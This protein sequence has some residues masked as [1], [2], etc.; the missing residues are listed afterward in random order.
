MAVF[1]RFETVREI[2]QTGLGSV[3]TAREAGTSGG[4]M[5][6]SA[7]LRSTLAPGERYIIKL[8]QPLGA[9][10]G[11]PQFDAEI[12]GFLR[13]VQ[14]QRRMAERAKRWA[15]V[16]ASGRFDEGAYAV[17]DAHSRSL[18]QFVLRKVDLWR[19]GNVRD[20]GSTLRAII[21]G[22][23]EAL[24]E[25]SG[26]ENG[27][28]HGSLRPSNVLLAG[29]GP[30]ATARPILTDPLAD[31]PPRHAE[32]ARRD[33]RDLGALIFQLVTHRP[34]RE[35]GAWPIEDG[36]EWR[37]YG[38]RGGP[39]WLDLCNRLLDPRAGASLPAL[40]QIHAELDAWPIERADRRIPIAI[41]AVVLL[42]LGGAGIWYATRPPPRP[43]LVL[44]GGQLDQLKDDINWIDALA[45]IAAD[46]TVAAA[47]RSDPALAAIVEPVRAYTAGDSLSRAIK[48]LRYER[49][50][51]DLEP[52]D[53]TVKLGVS[54]LWR[55][56]EPVT[57]AIAAWPV[58][59]SL[60]SAIQT[61]EQ[62][63]WTGVSRA[64][65]EARA[66][67]EAIL[68]SRPSQTADDSARAGEARPA[69]AIRS[70]LESARAADDIESLWKP[71]TAR[72]AE[73][74][75]TEDAVLKLYGPAIEG[76][77]RAA[78]SGD[79]TAESLQRELMELTRLGAEI[80]AAKEAHYAK[81]DLEFFAE[82]SRV[83][84]DLAKLAGAVSPEQAVALL[85]AWPGEIAQPQFIREP[86]GDVWA[87]RE[88]EDEVAAAAADMQRLEAKR[89]PGDEARLDPM[90]RHLKESQ[91]ALAGLLKKLEAPK[92]REYDAIRGDARTLLTGLDA[93]KVE[94][95]DLKEL[96][97]QEFEAY[98]PKFRART[99]ESGSAA[100]DSAFI[101][102]R[103]AIDK[104]H[105]DTKDIGELRDR[106]DR[107]A[108][109]LARL[110]ELPRVEGLSGPSAQIAMA[111][112]E[113]ALTEAIAQL[114][115]DAEG[116]PTAEAAASEVFNSFWAQRTGEYEAWLAEARAALIE[117]D[118]IANLLA[119][120]YGPAHDDGDG[121]LS[122][123]WARLA[124]QPAFGQL[125][126]QQESLRA[127]GTRLD[128]IAQINASTDRA[129]LMQTLE[130]A[131]TPLAEGMAA[132]SRLR[133][134]G[135]GPW[136]ASAEDLRRAATLLTGRLKP[137]AATA[138]SESRRA[139]LSGW[140]DDQAIKTWTAGFEAL[141][142]E[143][144]EIEAGA[145]LA[146]EF[147]VN[148]ADFAKL[149]PAAR[150]NL[151]LAGLRNEF[152]AAGTP[153]DDEA[154]RARLRRFDADVAGLGAGDAAMAGL[155]G[156]LREL[157]NAPPKKEVDLATVGPGS[158]G[159]T[160]TDA[161]AD[162]SWVVYAGPAASMPPLRFWRVSDGQAPG[163][164]PAAY[165]CEVETSLAMFAGI[166]EAAKG[167][168]DV[169]KLLTRLDA[170]PDPRKG[171]SAWSLTRR[172]ARGPS[173]PPI[174]LRTADTR[175]VG[176]GWLNVVA[177]MDRG[178]AYYPTGLQVSP[179]TVDCP[180]NYLPATAAI[181]TARLA[182]CRLPTPAEWT[183]A[184]AMNQPGTPN[185]RDKS[186][187]DQHA[188][189]VAQREGGKVN[190]PWPDEDIF[191]PEERKSEISARRRRTAQPVTDQDADRSLWFLP[192]S[193]TG[194]G[195]PFKHLRGN[196]AEV[197]FENSERLDG[198][199]PAA[200]L[201]NTD[202][203]G[204]K[205]AGGSA[206]SPVEVDTGQVYNAPSANAWYSDVG[207]R[208][209]FS[210]GE[211]K[212]KPLIVQAGQV[213]ATAKYIAGR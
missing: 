75:T 158:V 99:L 182:G 194:H 113:N 29:E 88:V 17:F 59:G 198:L 154:V 8:F 87:G 100:L 19:T 45:P 202:W 56:Y 204:L 169:M 2:S 177:G 153:P 164:A 104:A 155:A 92:R 183:A 97:L 180:M 77:A 137:L 186:W 67:Y 135:P 4:S 118:V 187:K 43:V 144:A 145:A 54:D 150:F 105:A 149:T 110:N 96:R 129:A 140:V 109:V 20:P 152:A 190:A 103:D 91:D 27:R 126:N 175:R 193:Q 86:I 94:I 106:A 173:R 117:A 123:R 24:Q 168:E 25:V 148:D 128:A 107:V 185:V 82:T 78:A 195:E 160:R 174:E 136:P 159:W 42:G 7:M 121:V 200:V 73:L 115:R 122:E 12:E 181:Y 5:T 62:R 49:A 197:L 32:Y 191:V 74:A 111:E 55:V 133:D 162:G 179:P 211:G 64:L 212:P 71:L 28:G 203:S 72:A 26:G 85:R 207:F 165:V 52:T 188:F 184:A 102:A 23:V 68:A 84:Q 166:I 132:W 138:R 101:R 40:E 60:A 79:Q 47:A 65:S 124:K 63:G 116:L 15:K 151:L 143:A 36:P 199:T 147:G 170:D 58:P 114:P 46:P 130:T 3:W 142:P 83:H 48:Y 167:G 98:L 176:Q 11:D 93:L 21:Q 108:K 196:V 70:V 90:N 1:G 171:P 9:I 201:G 205:I 178:E 16:H 127:I 34:F 13:R 39:K 131:A 35:L 192:V 119:D 18:Q 95:A 125:L 69:E 44:A 41:A 30:I 37:A 112:R 66:A 61:F 209:A 81:A 53:A 50:K 157:V 31:D 210:A 89:Q 33:R 139:Q 213:L 163:G 80:D 120:G 189:I 141:K 22:V 172:D 208:L 161:A 6:A 57:A 76:R 10:P 156:T 14:T 206:L 38:R 51:G 134:A 146:R